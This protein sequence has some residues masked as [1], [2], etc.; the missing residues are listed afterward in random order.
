MLKHSQS[1]VARVSH[2]LAR[3]EKRDWELWVVVSLTSILVSV[4]LLAIMLPGSFKG[5]TIHFEVTVSRP[6]AIG[7][8]VLLALLNTY[9]VTKRFEVRRLREQLIS[10][11]L[12]NQVTEQQSLTDPLTEIYNRRSL[13]QIAGQFISQARRR[14]LPLTFLMIDADNFKQVNTRFGHLTGDFVLAEIAGILKGSI[15]GSDAIIRYGGDEFVILLADT[16]ETGSLKVVNRINAKLA[17]WNDANHLDGFRMNVSIGTAE[18][19]D[20]ET[21][22]ELLDRADQKMYENKHVDPA[23]AHLSPA[24]S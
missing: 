6:L 12:Q 24:T 7:L 10:S 5:D 13:D 16:T 17:E 8:F 18:W 22:D 23:S 14:R 3:L 11:T 15:R 21:L 1:A 19:H 2:Q 20:G 9:L 4:G